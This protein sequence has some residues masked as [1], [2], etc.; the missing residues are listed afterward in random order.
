LGCFA[1]V[2]SRGVDG[3]LFSGVVV[4]FGTRRFY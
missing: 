1:R 3:E 2:V 4:R